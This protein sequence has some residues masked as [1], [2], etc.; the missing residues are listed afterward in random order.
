MTRLHNII[1]NETLKKKMEEETFERETVSFYKYV[2]IDEPQVCRDYLYKLFFSLQIFGRVYI[3]KEGINAQISIPDFQWQQF[4]TTIQS[5]PFLSNIRLNIGKKG[6]GKSF[7]VLKVKL[8]EKIVADGLDNLNPYT[9]P[10]G[11]YIDAT[12]TNEMMSKKETIVLDMRN[13]Y[14]YEVG[15]FTNAI[16][17]PADT[18]K[19]QLQQMLH[20]MKGKEETPIVMYCTGGIR[21]EKAS[22]YL[23]QHHFKQ[24]YHVEGGIIHY[25]HQVE[26]QGL[27]CKFIGKNFVFDHRL[28][29]RITSDI[30]ATCHQCGQP[31]DTHTNCMNAACHLLFIQCDACKKQY[32]GCCSHSCMEV[33]HLPIEKQKEIRKGIHKGK[34]IFNKSRSKRIKEIEL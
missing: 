27:D 20:M 34:N 14:E 3:A 15:H 24:V 31:A 18:F 26:K 30:I 29:E 5:V 32:E 28:G 13:H 10:T 23:I 7:W 33:I 17:V 16:E 22:A 6:N 19:E 21:C 11:K 1:S 9:I 12:T 4:I 25:A 8:R 2:P